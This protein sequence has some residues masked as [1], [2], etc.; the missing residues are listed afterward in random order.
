MEIGY[1]YVFMASNLSTNPRTNRVVRLSLSAD[2]MSA[3][4]RTDI[5]ADIAYKDVGNALRG[6]ARIAVGAYASVRI[7]FCT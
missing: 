4:G 6:R 3:S 5:I 2:N 1:V 7:A